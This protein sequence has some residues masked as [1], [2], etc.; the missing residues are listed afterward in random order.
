MRIT[1]G[2]KVVDHKE[3]KSLED[4]DNI[5]KVKEV[6]NAVIKNLNENDIK[7][8]KTMNSMLPVIF[9]EVSKSGFEKLLKDKNVYSLEVETEVYITN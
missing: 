8:I 2:I 7:S 5:I 6:Q 1:I 3:E 4:P 9:G